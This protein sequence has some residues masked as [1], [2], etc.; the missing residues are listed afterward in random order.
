M[1]KKGIDG[2]VNGVGK[3][4]N[5]SGRQIRFLQ[6]GQVGNYVLLMVIGILIMFIIQFLSK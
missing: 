1:E 4:V 2:F 3:A 6:S 5:Y